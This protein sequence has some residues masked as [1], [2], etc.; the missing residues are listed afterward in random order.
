M[1]P[2]LDLSAWLGP[3]SAG[4][5][6]FEARASLF[7]RVYPRWYRLDP[8]GLPERSADPAAE[9]VRASAGAA[10][11]ELWPRL[12]AAVPPPAGDW[13]PGVLARR[14]GQEG[15]RGICLDLGPAPGAAGADFVRALAPALRAAGLAC[16]LVAAPSDPGGPPPG[17]D[18]SGWAGLCDRLL[19][20]GYRPAGGPGPLAPPAWCATVLEGLA[21]VPASRIEWTLPAAGRLWDAAGSS[22]LPYAAWETLMRTRGPERRDPPS[23]EMFL[24]SPGAEAWANDAVSLTGKLRVVLLRGIRALSLDGLGH[25]DPRL[26]TLLDAL[27]DSVFIRS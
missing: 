22:E 15:A 20:R 4:A 25:E 9:R 18:W 13:D 6:A 16:A 2:A 7:R 12:E 27:P 23:G 26:W 17:A 24:R 11:V 5:E 19:V 10:G 21:G 8:R 14:L 1:N 3:G